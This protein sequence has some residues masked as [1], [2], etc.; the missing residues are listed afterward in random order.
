MTIQVQSLN[1]CPGRFVC[2]HKMTLLIILIISAVV[3]VVDQLYQ[4]LPYD[5][6]TKYIV[7]T[8][9]D[10]INATIISIMAIFGLNNLNR[11]RY[12]KLDENGIYSQEMVTMNV[13]SDAV[14]DKTNLK[15]KVNKPVDE[16]KQL[17]PNLKSTEPTAPMI[18]K[19]MYDQNSQQAY[20][21]TEHQLEQIR[22]N[23]ADPNNVPKIEVRS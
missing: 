21:L 15:K 12:S 7:S 14:N 9:T 8:I 3:T 1:C 10:G 5:E 20:L 19:Y 23:T 16:E 22:Q 18:H 4:K 6:Q 11:V 17:Y 13:Q 2:V